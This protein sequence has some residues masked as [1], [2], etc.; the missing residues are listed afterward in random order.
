MSPPLA[1]DRQQQVLTW[2][3]AF[4]LGISIGRW[5]GQ[6]R[7]RRKDRLNNPI[8][9]SSQLVAAWRAVESVEIDGKLFTDDIAAS[10]A[11]QKAF[12]HALAQAKVSALQLLTP[13]IGNL[14]SPGPT[15]DLSRVERTPRTCLSIDHY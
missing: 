6:W 1:L 8:S 2:G 10:L 15:L 13:L 11:G 14:P 4:L 5:L 12:A 9:R 7:E 3:S